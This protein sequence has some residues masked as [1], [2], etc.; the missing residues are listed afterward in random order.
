MANASVKLKWSPAGLS[1]KM[2][3]TDK[4]GQD[5][6]HEL[7]V[8]TYAPDI[9][10]F[11]WM[12]AYERM[13]DHLELRRRLAG[14]RDTPESERRREG[15]RT[16]GQGGQARRAAVSARHGGRGDRRCRVRKMN[17]NETGNGSEHMS[18]KTI[19]HLKA[20]LKTKHC[21][22]I[23]VNAV[24]EEMLENRDNPDM[25]KD[26]SVREHWLAKGLALKVETDALREMIETDDD[27]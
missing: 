7:K 10:E 19:E 13:S 8:T 17:L 6:F 25:W 21:E 1:F 14:G 9:D 23:G 26:V 24:L 5:C 27:S 4:R 12:E 3:S 16:Q 2:P 15:K 22:L 18:K 11:P 20:T